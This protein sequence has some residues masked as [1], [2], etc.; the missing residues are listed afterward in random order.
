MCTVVTD[1]RPGRPLRIL[2]VRDEV[3]SREFD[4]PGAWWAEHPGVVGGRDRVAGGSWCLSDVATGSTAMVLNRT[5]R[6]TGTPSRGELPLVAL[7][8]GEAWAEHLDHREMA[9][10]TLVLA[11]ASGVTAWTWTGTELTRDD[12]ADGMHL[13][14]SSG[15]DPATTKGRRYAPLLAAAD[16]LDVVT[17]EQ[18][19]DDLDALIIA[20][21]LDNGDV[22]G[23]LFGQLLVTEPGKLR[24]TWSRTPW[25][26]DGWQEL[27][28]PDPTRH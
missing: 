5:E 26:A 22:Y 27:T 9:S 11:T 24:A 19:V 14:T 13:F 25:L 15:I 16:W 6:F 23:T 3:R 2:A 4:E 28:L 1:L 10:F 12:L 7:A 8:Y 18:P 17:A 20:H 21:P